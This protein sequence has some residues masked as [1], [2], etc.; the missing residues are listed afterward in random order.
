[1]FYASFSFNFHLL[2]GGAQYNLESWSQMHAILIKDKLQFRSWFHFYSC[3]YLIIIRIFIS[4]RTSEVRVQF[5]QYPPQPLIP[6]VWFEIVDFRMQRVKKMGINSIFKEI[7][8][9]LID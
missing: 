8:K 2:I 9:V 1:M 6:T 3:D 7:M 5:I 4:V